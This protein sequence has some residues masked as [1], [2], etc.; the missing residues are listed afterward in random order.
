MGPYALAFSDWIRDTLV[1]PP[2]RVVEHQNGAWKSAVLHALIALGV[3]DALGLGAMTL[4]QLALQTGACQAGCCTAA[5][6]DWCDGVMQVLRARPA[7]ARSLSHPVQY[8]AEKH[9]E[10]NERLMSWAPCTSLR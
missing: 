4:T 10:C 7:C 9:W 1:P 3:P 8:S 6:S 2:L 5:C